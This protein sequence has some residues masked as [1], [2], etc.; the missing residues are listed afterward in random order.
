M[1]VVCNSLWLWKSQEHIR[2]HRVIKSFQLFSIIIQLKMKT[3]NKNKLMLKYTI[4]ID[5]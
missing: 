2:E 5:K 4:F 3:I 1:F